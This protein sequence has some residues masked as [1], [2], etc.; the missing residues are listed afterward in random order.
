[1]PSVADHATT[2]APPEEV[3]KLL[4]DPSRFPE[5]WAGMERVELG[6]ADGDFTFWYEGWP[7]FA[8]PQKL[9]TQRDGGRVTV[10]CLVSF[11]DIEWQLSEDGDGTRIDV[12]AAIPEAEAGRLEQ[13]RD[14]LAASV[15]RLAAVATDELPARG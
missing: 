13:V 1:M 11:M 3:W 9:V 8:M 5:W 10:S 12:R 14:H 7:D 2:A 15:R 4:Y 6:T